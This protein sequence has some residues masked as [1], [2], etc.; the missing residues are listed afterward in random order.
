M[1]ISA[2]PVAIGGGG[3]RLAPKHCILRNQ[4]SKLL[5]DD[6]HHLSC[7]LFYSAAR[8]SVSDEFSGF[9]HEGNTEPDSSTILEAALP[10]GSNLG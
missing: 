9:R 1:L 4:D 8:V 2:D 6:Y 10:S 5:K 3:S 7:A